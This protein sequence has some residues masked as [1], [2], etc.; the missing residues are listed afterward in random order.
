MNPSKSTNKSKNKGI[1]VERKSESIK[2]E[3]I[4]V[5]SKSER[6]KLNK[7]KLKVNYIIILLLSIYKKSIEDPQLTGKQP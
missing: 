3:S 5:E 2:V 7:I 4:K 1:K 6:S